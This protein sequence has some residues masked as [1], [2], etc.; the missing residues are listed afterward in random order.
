[1]KNNRR[2]KKQN[3]WFFIC[4]RGALV[5]SALT[6]LSV[7]LLAFLLKWDVLQPGSIRF[8]NTIIKALGAVIAGFICAKRMREKQWLF[9]GIAGLLYIV[10][11]YACFFLFEHRVEVN[12]IFLADILM[13]CICGSIFGIIPSVI[14]ESKECKDGRDH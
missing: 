4:L 12:L 8:C 7:L 2:H 10:V 5:A 9:S 13:G 14:F 11:A 6:I 3:P 1:M